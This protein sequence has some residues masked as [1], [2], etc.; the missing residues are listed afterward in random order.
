MA[1]GTPIVSSPNPGAR[2]VLGE[3]LAAL[4]FES[5]SDLGGAVVALL[6]DAAARQDRAEQGR[7]R[8]RRYSW[9][10]VVDQHV[11]AYA[12]AIGR[13]KGRRGSRV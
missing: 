7:E 4:A 8:V 13:F 12:A 2:H 9:D 11:E 5:D 10:A 1:N 6:T 3:T